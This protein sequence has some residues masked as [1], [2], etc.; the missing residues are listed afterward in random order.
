MVLLVFYLVSL[1]DLL[2]ILLSRSSE[3]LLMES[4][5]CLCII[6]LGNWNS[7]L[8]FPYSDLL[9]SMGVDRFSSYE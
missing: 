1:E 7:F 8:G 3:D 4:Q 2:F 5:V 9:M 6:G